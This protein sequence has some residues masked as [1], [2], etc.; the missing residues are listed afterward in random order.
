MKKLSYAVASLV[1]AFSAN[2]NAGI[3]VAHDNFDGASA[4]FNGNWGTDI[5]AAKSKPALTTVDGNKSLTFGSN[6]DR[7]AWWNLAETQTGGIIVDFSFSYTGTLG[8]NDFMGLW[9]GDKDGPSFGLKSNCDTGVCTDD[10]YVRTVGTG[11]PYLLGSDLVAGQSYH[12]L[13]YLSKTDGSEYYNSFAAWMNPTAYEMT[14]LTGADRVA[15]GASKISSVSQIGIRTVNIDKG[16]KVS[17]DNLRV[18][19]VPEPAT[20]SLFGLALAGLGLASRRKRG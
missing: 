18:S 5:T 15:T 2:A 19:E 17:I 11:G 10:L 20:L 1:F 14:S 4:G 7:A 8:N 13:G 9:L 12:L 16:V 3:V 6:N